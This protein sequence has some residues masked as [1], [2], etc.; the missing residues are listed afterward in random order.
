MERPEDY[1]TFS[2]TSWKGPI[3]S[4]PEAVA[5]SVPATPGI[6]AWRRIIPRD[7]NALK[8]PEEAVRWITH[9]VQS[10]IFRGGPIDL[11]SGASDDA[12]SKRRRRMRRGF[13]TIESLQIGGGHLPDS[14]RSHL[15]N[16][17][18]NDRSREYLYRLLR[19]SSDQYGPI[20]YVGSAT[21]TGGLRQRITQHVQERTS[22]AKRLKSAGIPLASMRVHVLPLPA[23]N[24]TTIELLEAL[25]THLLL[26]PLSVRAG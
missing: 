6:Y 13:A 15:H 4:D 14:K 19:E 8:S 10:P 25:L 23:V 12:D 17:V 26:A 2:S 3:P 21:K 5:Q 9:A 24:A 22:F 1:V 20:L 11:T 18:K 16:I 7:D